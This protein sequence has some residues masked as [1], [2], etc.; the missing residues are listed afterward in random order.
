[1]DDS[2][3][4]SASA[5]VQ[6]RL[7][8][9]ARLRTTVTNSRNNIMKLQNIYKGGCKRQPYRRRHRAQPTVVF[10]LESASGVARPP[11]RP[12]LYIHQPEPKRAAGP[13]H[14]TRLLQ[15]PFLH[16]SDCLPLGS[17]S[18]TRTLKGP[19]MGMIN[20]TRKMGE[21]GRDSTIYMRIRAAQIG[22]ARQ[23]AAAA[24]WANNNNKRKNPGKDGQNFA[25]LYS[26]TVQKNR[27]RPI[28]TSSAP[29]SQFIQSHSRYVTY[30]LRG[31]DNNVDKIR[32]KTYYRTTA[33]A[34]GVRYRR[35]M[36][37]GTVRNGGYNVRWTRSIADQTAADD[38]WPSD[39]KATVPECG[40]NHRNRFKSCLSRGF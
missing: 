14:S 10:T 13:A 6:K 21:A 17:L 2:L 15:L 29:G 37:F 16:K 4:F 27:Q 1:M 26:C 38:K 22:K 12:F 40:L 3:F 32:M 31:K 36:G 30:V 8:S 5:V 23:G 11:S 18:P 20:G 28:I 25:S 35:F 9:S 33:L 24:E 7:A 39:E 19:V 34:H